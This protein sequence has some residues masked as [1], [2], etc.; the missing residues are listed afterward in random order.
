LK[1]S[2]LSIATPV[3]K[4]HKDE[5]EIPE[6]DFNVMFPERI[7]EGDMGKR[8]PLWPLADLK[9]DG[10][11]VMSVEKSLVK[12]GGAKMTLE[13]LYPEQGDR[14]VDGAHAED[15]ISTPVSNNIST[16]ARRSVLLTAELLELILSFLPSPDLWHAR[17]VCQSW[18]ELIMTSPSLLRVLWFTSNLPAQIAARNVTPKDVFTVNPVLESLNLVNTERYGHY[19]FASFNFPARWRVVKAP[20]RDLQICK[21]P[22]QR[23]F[24]SSSWLEKY[25]ECETGLTAGMIAD[26]VELSRVGTLSSFHSA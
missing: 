7:P 15:T 25:L 9:E 24:L 23:V 4:V 8:P 3:P 20:W 12:K 2:A 5:I 16:D 11:V 14:K 6:S 10:N 26:K 19:K 17:N 13:E 18:D 21:P 1:P 22:I